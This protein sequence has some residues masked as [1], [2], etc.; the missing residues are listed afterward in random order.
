M[1]DSVTGYYV[2]FYHGELQP[3]RFIIKDSA[4]I[5]WTEK[6]LNDIQNFMHTLLHIFRGSKTV[7]AIC[8]FTV[9]WNAQMFKRPVLIFLIFKK[10][11]YEIFN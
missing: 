10:I 9:L 4:K 5:N 11:I 1:F 3:I 6:K 8:M 2:T 7:I